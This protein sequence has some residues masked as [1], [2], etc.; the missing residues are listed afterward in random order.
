MYKGTGLRRQTKI[1]TN[2][3][4]WKI[5]H[6]DENNNWT[7][8]KH[9]ELQLKKK[10]PVQMNLAVCFFWKYH[11]FERCREIVKERVTKYKCLTALNKSKN[12][13]SSETY[14]LQTNSI[15]YFGMICKYTWLKFYETLEHYTIF[16]H[17]LKGTQPF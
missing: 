9:F 16:K 6:D 7:S 14:G 5:W 8:T 12:R 15:S 13:K 10:M 11:P 3:Q 1:K 4:W 17:I 2:H